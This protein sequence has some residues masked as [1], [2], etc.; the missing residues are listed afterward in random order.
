[1]GPRCAPTDRDPKLRSK[2]VPLRRKLARFSLL[3]AGLSGLLVCGLLLLYESYSIKGDLAHRLEDIADMGRANRASALAADDPQVARAL[4][5]SLT[6]PDSVR[7]AGFYDSNG[8]LVASYVKESAR[9][10][11]P[12]HQPPQGTNENGGMLWVVRPVPENGGAICL[13]GDLS[14]LAKKVLLNLM[15]TVLALFICLGASMLVLLRFLRA[16]VEPILGLTRMAHQVS[17]TRA[18][19]LRAKPGPDDEVGELVDAFNDMLSEI[20]TRDIEL[21]THRNNLEELIDARTRELVAAKDKAEEGARLKG[22]FVANMSHEIRT[23]LNGVLGMTDLALETH[24]DVIQKEY[25]ETIKTSAETL[26]AV[27]NDVLDFSKIEAG[28]MD[29]E[30]ISFSPHSVMAAA[31]RTL[32]FKAKEKGIALRW[33]ASRDLPPM[34]LGDPL[35]LKQVLLN[36]IGNAVKFTSTGEVR[37]D[38]SVE[39]DASAQGAAASKRVP[40]TLP[41]RPLCAGLLES[42]ESGNIVFSITDTGIGIPQSK[43]SAIFEPFRQADGS[44]TR[45]FG[46]TGLGLSICSKLVELMGGEIG[47]ESE[48]GKGSRFWFTVPL[49]ISPILAEPAVRKSTTVPLRSIPLHV[50][51]AEDNLVNQRVATRMLE[52]MGHRVTVA[53]NGAEVIDLWRQE[54]IDVILMDVQMPVMS[55]F[56][57]TARIRERERAGGR[58]TPIIALTAHAVKGDRE[59]CLTAGMDDYIT[60]PVKFELLAAALNRSVAH[61]VL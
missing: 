12:D 57:A 50:L 56:D 27:I 14:A 2:S 33:N 5:Q 55:G 30:C 25:L 35:R 54:T 17:A 4:L 21:K 28:K 53:S 51:L 39:K 52:K 41:P 9:V 36:I 1:M 13:V 6:I 61:P 22:E 46:G 37:L 26:M 59:R 3:S 19:E 47:V 34:V 42:F 45:Q 23:P 48:A 58:R 16:T 24:L 40:E 43:I 31:A 32:A 49:R 18:Y 10:S 29:V 60:K 38:A 7:G 15:G 44:D 8:A 20:E 11:I